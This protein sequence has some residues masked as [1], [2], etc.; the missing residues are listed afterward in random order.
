MMYNRGLLPIIFMTALFAICGCKASNDTNYPVK[1]SGLVVDDMQFSTPPLFYWLDNHRITMVTRGKIVEDPIMDQYRKIGLKVWN[2]DTDKID[3]LIA[4]IEANIAYLCVS[5]SLVRFGTIAFNDKGQ[6]NNLYVAELNQ[7]KQVSNI[8]SDTQAG[9]RDPFT[10]RLKSNNKLPDWAKKIPP[11]NIH[12]LR[13]EH[14]FIFIDRDTNKWGTP[15]YGLRDIHSVRLHKLDEQVKQGIDLPII[16]EENSNQKNN[17][18]FQ[19][20]YYKYKDAY[21][22]RLCCYDTPL[23]WVHPNGKVEMEWEPKESDFDKLKMGIPVEYTATKIGLI[24]RLVDPIV[25]GKADLLKVNGHGD[26]SYITKG[27]VGQSFQVSPDGC[28]VAFLNDD[29]KYID[30]RRPMLFRKLQVINLCLEKNNGNT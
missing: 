30:S 16:P 13:P 10:C 25:I 3:D 17:Y 15:N 1:D 29:R 18:S 5:D 26:F 7:K 28:S 23:Y 22:I 20:E 11:M 9:E 2:I 19:P 4:P 6:Q 8:Q 12:L 24:F 27:R 21:L 14:G